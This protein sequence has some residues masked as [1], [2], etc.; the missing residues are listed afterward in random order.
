MA[1]PQ[2][3]DVFP[4]LELARELRDTIYVEALNHGTTYL[5]G[6]VESDIDGDNRDWDIRLSVSASPRT[7]I[8]LTNHKLSAEY[9]EMWEKMAILNAV[10]HVNSAVGPVRLRVPKTLRLLR[11]VHTYMYLFGASLDCE[12]DTPSSC[13][14]CERGREL[15]F[16]LRW[17]N[18]LVQSMQQLSSL[19]LDIYIEERMLAQSNLG[20]IEAHAE[21]LGL[22]LDGQF[23]GCMTVWAVNTNPLE[24]Q[25]DATRRRAVMRWEIEAR[26][27]RLLTEQSAAENGSR[28]H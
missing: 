11:S 25:Y 6:C 27:L 20:T 23:K 1:A 13:T 18:T 2:R 26:E 21:R 9:Q 8:L 22:L 19:N 28:Q 3:R 10:D 12:T 5:V 7:E 17:A 16:H 15:A 4:L 14:E 24:N